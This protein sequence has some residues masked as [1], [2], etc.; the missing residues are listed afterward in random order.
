M[1]ADAALARLAARRYGLFRLQDARCVGVTS[2]ML[3]KRVRDG[4]IERPEPGIYRFVSAPPTWHQSV[5]AACWAERGVASHRTAAALWQF[6]G[7]RPGLVEVLTERWRRRP[8]RSVRVHE[9]RLL[10][11]V[12]LDEV[13]IIPVTSRART[14]VDLGA[15]LPPQRV[16]EAL[17]GALNRKEVTPEAVWECVERLDSPGRPWVAVTRRL[18]ARRLGL[19]SVLPNVFE[20][21]LF[22]VLELAGIR[23]PEA[24]VEIRRPDGTTIGR[25]DWLYAR[26]RVVIECD[27]EQWHG[28]WRRRKADIRRDR[29]LAALGYTVLRVTWEDLID[30]PHQVVADVLG[31]L[32]RIVA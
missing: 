8:N 5:L 4:V 17:D 18:V 30:F 27:S 13:D 1:D 16:E 9:T 25:V 26:E 20:R 19:E 10:P 7:C 15:C 29:Q 23:P 11:D 22:T 6:D 31:A 28:G 32:S 24:Q 21:K 14:I 3:T 2:D 12:D